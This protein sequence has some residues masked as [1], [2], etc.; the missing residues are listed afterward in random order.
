MRVADAIGRTLAAHGI[1]RAFGMPGGE[2]VT[3]IDGLE[4]AGIR[5]VLAR[6]ESAAAI[7]A[8]GTVAASGSPGLLVTTLGPGLA[9]AVNGIVDAV[10]ERVPLIVISGVIDQDV[11]GRYTHQAFDHAALLRPLVKASFEIEAD[12]AA[13]VVARAIRLACTAPMG[14]V[15]L[16][17]SP[18]TA[19]ASSIGPDVVPPS[20]RLAASMP[21]DTE[22]WREIVGI[23]RRSERPLVIA[24]FE[25][26][27]SNAGMSLAELSERIGAP[28]ITTYKAKGIYPERSSL[29]LG[30]AGLSPLADGEI[31]KIVRSAD[32]VILAGYDPIEM[33]TGWLDPFAGEACVIEVSACPA[34]HGAHQAHYSVVAD[35]GA[36]LSALVM[37]LADKRTWG[38]GE[39]QAARAALRALFAAPS[40]WGPHAVFETLEETLPTDAI[41]T[42]DSGAHRIL[43]SQQILLDRPNRLL[44][45]A[46]LC[47][48]GAAVPLAIGH[49]CA[50]PECPVVAVLGDGGLEMSMGELGTMRDQGLPIVVVVLQDQSL[51]LIELKQ[52]QAGLE[53]AAVNLGPTR[54]EKVA[55][56]FG[57][58][59]VRVASRQALRSVLS[60]AFTAHV[61]T[62][63]VCDIEAVDYAGRI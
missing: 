5:F 30:G 53:R 23:V 42:V 28:V 40:E 60:E 61:F 49:A 17:L 56:A 46:G 10:Q 62:L 34:D 31:L 2:V 12:G 13:M 27:R 26:V 51:A 36:V 1:S 54:Y 32:T 15:H 55:E 3:L 41:L 24:G 11:R 25:A 19:A 4:R 14:P 50:K 8:A 16:D 59:G 39:P 43:L 22:T 38:G 18:A 6:N 58:R 44:Q 7:M 47:T 9:T 45:S 29:S 57:G 20:R 37:R 35:V 52:A 63:I 21:P 33:R 48:M